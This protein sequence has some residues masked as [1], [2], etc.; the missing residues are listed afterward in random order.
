MATLDVRDE[1]VCVFEFKYVLKLLY[2]VGDLRF[3]G[4]ELKALTSIDSKF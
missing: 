3:G 1:K 2:I 4:R